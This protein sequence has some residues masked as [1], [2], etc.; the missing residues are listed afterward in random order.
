MSNSSEICISFS[1]LHS[2]L[3]GFLGQLWCCKRVP[4]VP[5]YMVTSFLIKYIEAS[6]DYFKYFEKYLTK[7]FFERNVSVGVNVLRCT[8]I[9]A[10]LLQDIYLSSL[11][12]PRIGIFNCLHQIVPCPLPYRIGRF[13]VRLKIENAKM[14]YS[15][16]RIVTN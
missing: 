4:V 6:K 1:I 11:Y 8:F 10:D 13:W 5:R 2:S 15:I 12:N 7:T 14:M 3:S 9:L 16:R